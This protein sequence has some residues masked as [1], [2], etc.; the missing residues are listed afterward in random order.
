MLEILVALERSKA[1]RP[2][3]T[4]G[5]ENSPKRG[6]P[7]TS[8]VRRRTKGSVRAIEREL[9]EGDCR[10]WADMLGCSQVEKVAGE[11][12]AF[13]RYKAG[14]Q[15]RSGRPRR[16]DLSQGTRLVTHNHRSWPI[17]ER[18]NLSSH[19]PPF[20]DSFISSGRFS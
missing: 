8:K 5:G 10:D 13:L 20:H 9:L 11:G 15:V 12:A 2:L 17:A 18:P 3:R 7:D 19:S 16:N 1:S 6:D 14:D 4:D